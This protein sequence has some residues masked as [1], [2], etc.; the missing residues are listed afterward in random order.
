MGSSWSGCVITAGDELEKDM[1]DH[2]QE[3]LSKRIGMKIVRTR[4][5]KRVNCWVLILEKVQNFMPMLIQKVYRHATV[6]SVK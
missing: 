3:S 4:R 6:E 1:M 2:W 5:I